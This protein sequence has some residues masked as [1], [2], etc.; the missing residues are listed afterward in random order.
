[1]AT[2]LLFSLVHSLART[3]SFSRVRMCILFL[4][5]FHTCGNAPLHDSIIV[6]KMSG[7][8]ESILCD[9]PDWW[10]CDLVDCSS[11]HSSYH[12]LLLLRATEDS[13]SMRFFMFVFQRCAPPVPKERILCQ[14]ACDGAAFLHLGKY[15]LQIK[16]S[17]FPGNEVFFFFR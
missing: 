12:Q 5:P 2:H 11:V 6:E 1:M 10:L 17:C 9:W 8:P 7:C 14:H 16:I 15:A 3:G 4:S 13:Q